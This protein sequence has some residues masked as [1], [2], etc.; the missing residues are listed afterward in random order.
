MQHFESLRFAARIIEIYRVN[1]IVRV[2]KLTI[3]R[4]QIEKEQ[5]EKNIYL[6]FQ[7]YYK[8][9]FR[10]TDSTVKSTRNVLKSQSEMNIIRKYNT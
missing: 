9:I 2:F 1:R 6:E 3:S 4:W 7:Y 5:K 8:M 10:S